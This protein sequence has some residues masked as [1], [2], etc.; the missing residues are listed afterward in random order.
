MRYLLF[1]SSIWLNMKTNQAFSQLGNELTS[2][3]FH[4]FDCLLFSFVL[5]ITLIA[6]ITQ[7]VLSFLYKLC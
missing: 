2:T 3:I 5:T 1:V 7:N 6:T 4:I